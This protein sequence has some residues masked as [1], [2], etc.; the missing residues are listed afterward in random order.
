[1]GEKESRVTTL[2]LDL[3]K[4]NR[5]ESAL[6]LDFECG[7]RIMDL[8]LPDGDLLTNDFPRSRVTTLFLDLINKNDQKVRLP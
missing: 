6:T 1:M 4:K 7:R 8:P 2:F 5:S 3:V